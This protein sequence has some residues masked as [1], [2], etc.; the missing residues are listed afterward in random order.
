MRSGQQKFRDQLVIRDKKCIISGHSATLCDA[1]H[2]IP[3]YLT[4]NNDVSNGILIS[5][6][7]HK[8]FDEYMWSIN[9]ITNILI[10]PERHHDLKIAKYNKK[11]ITIP[12][13]CK[14]AFKEHYKVFLS[15]YLGIKLTEI[16]NYV[17]KNKENIS[18]I[19]IRFKLQCIYKTNA[20]IA[21]FVIKYY[22]E[23]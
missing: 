11:Y 19:M 12:L 5:K 14:K 18:D 16:V 3:H 8:P 1:C 17:K 20:D 2:I 15:N 6:L 7:H 10:V 23:L 9:P 21:D 4:Q 13:E 22:N